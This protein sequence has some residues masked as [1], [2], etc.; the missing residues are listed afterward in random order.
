[1]ITTTDGMEVSLLIRLKKVYAIAFVSIK[2][3]KTTTGQMMCR[4]NKHICVLVCRP[5]I[6]KD[7]NAYHPHSQFFDRG[8]FKHVQLIYSNFHL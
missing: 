2:T 8:L 4:A 6:I 7:D 5:H 1:M 3:I